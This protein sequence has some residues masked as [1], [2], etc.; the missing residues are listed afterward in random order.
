[1]KPITNDPDFNDDAKAAAE[2]AEMEAEFAALLSQHLPGGDNEQPRGELIEVTVVA[3]RDEKVFVDLRGKAEA[4]VALDEFPAGDDGKRDIKVGQVIPV[5]Q[6]GRNDDGTPRLSYR[7]A[8]NREAQKHI[9]EAQENKVPMRGTVR[10]IVKGGV[11][12]DIGIDAFMPASQ[13]DLFKIPDLNSLLGQEIEAY[14]LEYDPRRNRAVLSRRQLLF[15][16]REG[17]KKG[18]IDTLVPGATVVGKI[19]NVLEFGVFVELGMADGFIPREEISWDRGR[20]P[21]DV[22]K[23]GDEVEVRILNVSPETGKITL[24]RKRLSENPWEKI[25][26]RYPV[27]SIVRGRI[28]A[29][30]A[31][32]AFVH[33]EEG[34][35]GM[36]HASDMSWAAGNKKPQDYVRVGDEVTSQVLEVD[37]EKR[38]LSLGLKQLARD[39]WQDVKD[40]YKTGDRHEG[41]VVSLTNY[42]A[43]IRITDGVEGMVH[44]SDLTWERRINHPK[45][46]LKVG[47]TVQVVVLKLDDENR[48]IS[49][50]IKQLADSPYDAYMKANPV[51]SVVKGTVSRFAPFG[52]FVLLAPGLEGLIHI[53]QI[54]E[55]RV[56]VPEKALKLGEEVTVKITGAEKKHQKISLS[57]REAIKTL[58]R[59]NIKAYMKTNNKKEGATGMNFGEALRLA[60]E[61]K[62]N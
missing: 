44:V 14:V 9:R 10:S 29:L 45:E 8:R 60:K 55:K 53:S 51:N 23:V 30:Q 17:Q 34:I 35:T 49:L 62:D 46:I 40:T 24:T 50:G 3:L 36:I 56:E 21:G 52:A 7:M 22:M 61:K 28:I 12:V 42:G 27:G 33:V 39:P 20:A 6:V 43:F 1:M 15:E 54:D 32:G 4:Y 47:E 59:D 31:Y 38:R 5:I 25:E 18:F 58:E 26:E 11:M 19:K 41:T 37:R 48:R 57:R 2:D 16:R 13:I